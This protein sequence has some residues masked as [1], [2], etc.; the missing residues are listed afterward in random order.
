MKGYVRE[1]ILFL[2]CV[3]NHIHYHYLGHWISFL[4]TQVKVSGTLN[5]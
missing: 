4:F 3:L 1:Q 5:F 2:Y